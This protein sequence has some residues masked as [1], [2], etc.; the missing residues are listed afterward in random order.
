MESIFCEVRQAV[1]FPGRLSTEHT[2]GVEA[3]LR[4]HYQSQNANIKETN[5]LACQQL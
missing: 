4:E 5:N 2:D 1:S 3:N